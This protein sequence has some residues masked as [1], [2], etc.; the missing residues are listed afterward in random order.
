MKDQ[1]DMT[2]QE[3]YER[4]AL[5]RKKLLDFL[6]TEQWTTYDVIS[7]LIG[8][9]RQNSQKLV[10]KLEKDGLITIDSSRRDLYGH[11]RT[12]VG[13]TQEGIVSSGVALDD[14]CTPYSSGRAPLS[15]IRH[16]S[17]CQLARIEAEAFGW[18]N[19][20]PDRLL[21]AGSPPGLKANK[22]R[23]VGKIPD[24]ICNDCNGAK[25]AL[26]M[27]TSIKT[28]SR[29]KEI[30]A[31]HIYSIERKHR[32]DRVLY[33]SDSDKRL[34]ALKQVIGRIERVYLETGW[35]AID[36]YLRYFVFKAP[37]EYKK[38]LDFARAV[39]LEDI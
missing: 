20:V 19:F 4:A 24:Y 18:K 29:Y 32:Y 14:A 8:S 33:L 2:R 28:P 38:Y 35:C 9:Q 30:I 22:A 15:Q 7:A 11:P 25:V 3:R 37:S 13:I 6:A 31:A 27:E 36:P 12:V 16:S 39:P 17:A 10:K 1:L 5:K 26:E 23:I 34:H 21:K